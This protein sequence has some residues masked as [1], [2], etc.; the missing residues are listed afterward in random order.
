MDGKSGG[1]IG[2]V[3]ALLLVFIVLKLVGYIAWSWWWVLSPAWI[4]VALLVLG[5]VFVGLWAA[6]VPGAKRDRKSP[7]GR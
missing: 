5:V 6:F 4:G 2:F 1:G 7:R 3:G